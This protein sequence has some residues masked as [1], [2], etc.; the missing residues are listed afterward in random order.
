[1]ASWEDFER[2]EPGMA[3]AGL[4]E[5]TRF[6]AAIAYLATVQADGSPQVHPVC[7][8]IAD[9][10]LYVSIGHTS[11]KLR[12]LRRDGRYMLHCLPGDNDAEF[13]VRG[14]ATE[15]NDPVAR[16]RI[17][18]A[19]NDLGLNVKD[20]EIVF[21]LDIERADTAYWE[22]VGQPDTRAIRRKWLAPARRG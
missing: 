17:V 9:G 15:A 16:E 22:N 7:P 13:S 6:R 5:L 18:A 12:H 4:R 8:V 14:R 20:S 21:R 2:A 11:P 10:Q 19:A 3:E 1:M